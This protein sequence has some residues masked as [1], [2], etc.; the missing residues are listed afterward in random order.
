M[1]CYQLTWCV[2]NVTIFAC[3]I[4][5]HRRG[6]NGKNTSANATSLVYTATKLEMKCNVRLQMQ[7]E[8]KREGKGTSKRAATQTALGN[9]NN[10]WIKNIRVKTGSEYKGHKKHGVWIINMVG[11]KSSLLSY[12]HFSLGGV[13][14]HHFHITACWNMTGRTF[15]MLNPEYYIWVQPSEHRYYFSTNSLFWLYHNTR[16]TT[17]TGLHL[18]MDR[19]IIVQCFNTVDDVTISFYSSFYHIFSSWLGHIQRLWITKLIF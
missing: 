6:K 18:R 11:K 9:R 19:Q 14:N 1:G 3:R 10:I 2:N 8:L 17:L 5:G 16:F 4:S 12:S 13:E 15:D 7:S